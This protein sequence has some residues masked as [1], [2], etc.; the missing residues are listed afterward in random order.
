MRAWYS[1][2]TMKTLNRDY[3]IDFW[4]KKGE[5][6]YTRALLSFGA[7]IC[8][9]SQGVWANDKWEKAELTA[10]EEMK[11]NPDL[12]KYEVSQIKEAE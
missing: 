7:E 2:L 3:Q 5:H 10:Q 9:S 6:V 11:K 12:V 8:H 1:C 4:N